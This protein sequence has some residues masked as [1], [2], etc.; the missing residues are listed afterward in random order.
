MKILL[1]VLFGSGQSRQGF[2]WEKDALQNICLVLGLINA[3]RNVLRI[4]YKGLLWLG[5][6]CNSFTTMSISQH[7]RSAAYPYG[8]QVWPFVIQ[9][10]TICS[11]SCLLVLVAVVRSVGFFIENPLR[12]TIDFWP[13]LNFLI[14]QSWLG[15][16][17][18]SWQLCWINWI[19]QSF[20][21]CWHS[22]QAQDRNSGF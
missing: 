9:G 2:D 13:Y 10:N 11:R 8:R 1:W 3:L 17:R 5:V 7:R 18:V 15:V 4:Q 22:F 19:T 12:S 14:H 16:Q 6:P 21:V 20:Y